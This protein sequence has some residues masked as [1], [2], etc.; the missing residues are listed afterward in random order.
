MG[1]ISASFFWPS[2]SNYSSK[3][4]NLVRNLLTPDPDKRL[5]PLEL[6]KTLNN[7]HALDRIILND[8]AEKIK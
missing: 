8:Q 5:S 1:I 6:Q 4:E 3:L 7:W 2:E